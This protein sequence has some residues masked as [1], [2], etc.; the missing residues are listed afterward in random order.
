MNIEENLVSHLLPQIYRHINMAVRSAFKEAME[1]SSRKNLS[2]ESSID[3]DYLSAE[4]AA[5]F[6][7]LKLCTIYSKAEKGDLPYSRSGKRKLLFS[8][9]ELEAYVAKRKVKSHDEINE[10]VETY[11]NNR[12]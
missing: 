11:K 8:K 2:Q 6:L 4:Q 12:R 1:Q 5:S 9:K 10:E 3:E 7:K